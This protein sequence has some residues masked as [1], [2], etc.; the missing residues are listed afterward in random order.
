MVVSI[1]E[2]KNKRNRYPD[3][4]GPEARAAFEKTRKRNRNEKIAAFILGLAMIGAT[5]FG[6]HEIKERGQQKP[7]EAADL[8]NDEDAENS[9]P[10]FEPNGG[11]IPSLAEIDENE[12][13]EIMKSFTPLADNE[14]FVLE[15]GGSIRNSLYSGDIEHLS[16]ILLSKEET[17]LDD[18]R[19]VGTVYARGDKYYAIKLKTMPNEVQEYIADKNVQIF[20]A[21]GTSLVFVNKIDGKIITIELPL[22]QTSADSVST[23]GTEQITFDQVA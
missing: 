6:V 23:Q 19:E 5:A 12:A 3:Y 8:L 21:D 22:E 20:E 13:A 1:M 17:T 18:V 7:T 14:K 15:E 11:A 16:T 9:S 2:Q 4:V 10:K